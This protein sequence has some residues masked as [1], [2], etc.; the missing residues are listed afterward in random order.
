MK[1]ISTFLLW[2]KCLWI[3]CKA[4]QHIF[5][6]EIPCNNCLVIDE[7]APARLQRVWLPT[8]FKFAHVTICQKN[9][10][11]MLRCLV[12]VPCFEVLRTRQPAGAS[13]VCAKQIATSCSAGTP[14][15]RRG[16]SVNSRAAQQ[17]CEGGGQRTLFGRF[18]DLFL[19]IAGFFSSCCH[20][21]LVFSHSRKRITVS[22]GI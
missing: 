5:A 2:I 6:H 1:R 7:W 11:Q 12:F 19:R 17:V 4:E 3:V 16:S 18:S 10:P 22:E 8:C 13:P 14:G 21:I 20:R 9:A 15:A